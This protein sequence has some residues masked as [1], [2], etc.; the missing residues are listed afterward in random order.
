[1]KI[2]AFDTSQT[3][4]AIAVSNNGKTNTIQI[5]A[6]KQQAK[7]ILPAIQDLLNSVSLSLSELDVIAYGRGPGSFTGIRIASSVAQGLAFAYQKP[8]I[9]LSSLAILAEAAYLAS[10]G[11]HFLVAV[12]AR[13]DH[14]Y[15]A[16]YEKQADEGLTLNGEEL[17]CRLT[18]IRLTKPILTTEKCM[19]IGDGWEK[20]AN[21]ISST[22][23]LQPS[24]DNKPLPIA[25]VLINLAERQFDKKN[26]VEALEALPV[27][28][29]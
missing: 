24:L 20:Y 27:Y 6:P 7:L 1:M 21:E 18:E 11:R 3:I 4:C 26:W 13:M 15:W 19:G 5:N 17:A 16:H 10:G 28:L 23:H 14:L 25:Q 22:I 12:D 8:V 9:P 2:L 29:R